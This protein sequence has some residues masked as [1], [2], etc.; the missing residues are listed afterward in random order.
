[1]RLYKIWIPELNMTVRFKVLSPEDV[2][3]FLNDVGPTEDDNHFCKVVLESLVFNMKTEIRESLRLMSEE[4][5][6]RVLSALYAGCVMLNPGLDPALWVN[7]SYAKHFE[8][9]LSSPST[10]LVPVEVDA[11]TAVEVTPAVKRKK[12]SNTKFNSLRQVLEEQVVGQD[13]ALNAVCN[14]LKRSQA[15]LADPLRPLGVFVFAGPSGVGKTHLAKVLHKHMYGSAKLVRLDMSEYQHKH[16]NQK[17]IGSPPGY[18]GHDEGGQLTNAVLANPNTVL[19]LDEVEKAHPD[20][21][22]TFLR[23]FEDGVATD[24]HGRE[25]DFRNTIVIMT[26]NLG[27]DKVVADMTRRGTGFNGRIEHVLSTKELPPRASV[28]RITNEEVSKFFKPEFLNR[29]DAIVVFN[30]LAPADYVQIAD[31]EM[32]TLDEKLSKKGISFSW[33]ETVVEALIDQGVDTTM[34]ARGME[35]IRR[36]K[37]ETILADAILSL[38][39]TRG[40]IFDLTHG[41]TFNLDVRKP[42]KQ[43][44]AVAK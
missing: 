39:V 27:N 19:L 38:K 43:G 35:K 24:S 10:D 40:T 30:H 41:D 33:D 15:G 12:L 2:S 34:G 22:S 20:V 6:G 3:V 8:P 37:I 42:I 23:I 31:L 17:L 25:V 18:I 5:A 4:A 32:R 28:E 29:I 9:T 26:T 14:A 44:K 7:I 13:E 36:L 1:M 16:D 21:W 11:E